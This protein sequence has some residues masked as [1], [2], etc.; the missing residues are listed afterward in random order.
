MEEKIKLNFNEEQTQ[1]F[2]LSYWQKVKEWIRRVLDPK[3]EKPLHGK[4]LDDYL[5]S[6]GK[7]EEE[8]ELIADMCAE[9]DTFH[10]KRREFETS[11]KDIE[12]WY[13][14][15]LERL[16]KEV[17]PNATSKDV[18]AVEEAVAKQVD[19]EISESADELEEYGK[20]M[21]SEKSME[22]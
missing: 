21:N 13:D 10:Q 3:G 20:I 6:Q 1:D 14:K 8:K 4:E 22:D 19:D 17:D 5:V 15:E 9:I 16:T 7:S 18:D 12:T 11:G 2:K